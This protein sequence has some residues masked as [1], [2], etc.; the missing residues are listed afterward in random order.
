[1]SPQIN[2]SQN[3][4]RSLTALSGKGLKDIFSFQ[5]R[6]WET[7]YCFA[8]NL[9]PESYELRGPSLDSLKFLGILFI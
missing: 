4:R 8:G 2:S 1:M 5:M 3:F 9:F 6:L 7:Q